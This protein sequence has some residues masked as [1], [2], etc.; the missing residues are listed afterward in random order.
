M[1]KHNDGKKLMRKEKRNAFRLKATQFLK[2]NHRAVAAV[3]IAVFMAGY[4]S[5]VASI[6]AYAVYSGE[7]V[8]IGEPARNI[9]TYDKPSTKISKKHNFLNGIYKL[10]GDYND[11]QQ[12][13]L[14]IGSGDLGAAIY[15][16]TAVERIVFNEKTLW[17]GGPKDGQTDYNGDNFTGVGADGYTENERYY[18]VQDYLLN[19]DTK[20]ATK[21]F[22]NMEGNTENKGAYL[23]FADILIDFGHK[24]VKN[25]TRSLDVDN[26]LASVNYT[27]KDQNF[28]REY[29]ASNP[30]KVVAMRFNTDGELSFTLRFPARQAGATVTADGNE[31]T[32][33][34]ALSG[35]GLKYY[36]CLTVKSHGGTV[37]ANGDALTISGGQTADVFVSAITD[38]KDEYP[39]YRTGESAEV[40]AM[41]V[42]NAVAAAASKGYDGVKK[43]HIADYKNLF[44][45]VSLN[46]GG[47]RPDFTTDKLL[48]KYSTIFLKNSHRRYLEQLLYN[49][50]RYLL[51]A[52]SR[53]DSKLPANLQGV[54]N[55][56][57]N[58]PW[59][60]DYHLNINLQMNYWAAYN[61][62]LAECAEPLVDFVDA[63]R[64]PGRITAKTYT[65][66]AEE[67]AANLAD[68]EYGFIAHTES[69]PYGHTTPGS[70]K[71]V[72]AMWSPAAVAWL[73]Q[74]LYE[75]YEYGQD[76][77]YLARIYPIMKEAARY[78]ERTMV[79]Y[80]GRLVTAPCY[81]PEHGKL[82]AGNTYEQSL[83]WQLLTDVTAAAK[84]LNVDAD[85]QAVWTDMITKLNP[86][87]IGSGG[88][89]KEWYD[90][91]YILSR[92]NAFHR[93]TSHLLGVFPGDLINKDTNPEYVAA[94]K[95]S[96]DWRGNLST[97]WAMGQRI[98]T[99]A[100]L[101][102]GDIAHKLIKTLFK[103][104][105]YPNLFDAHPP[106]QID[107]NFGYTSGVT[108][109]LMQ[110][111]L[112]YIDLLPAL[113]SA[114][115]QGK[116][117]GIVARGNFT[118]A[119][120]WKDGAVTE[121]S[122]RSGSGNECVIRVDNPSDYIVQRSNGTTVSSKISDGKLVFDT[123]VGETYKVIKK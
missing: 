66:T 100:R 111:N 38:Y 105:I 28:S 15:G 61:T 30:D 114:W 17:S 92:G 27:Y 116:I 33:S 64:E 86:I 107:G 83:I 88:Q 97:G 119:Y 49:Y 26:A 11:F 75:G 109:M 3:S 63:L 59:Q 50:G 29:L 12:A 80:N 99:Y 55:E 10:D 115:A 2:K 23:P 71:Y 57:D 47:V 53:A 5:G 118:L 84:T 43:T 98:N 95:V 1:K 62:N 8:T 13:S 44:D 103:N 104:G 68:E 65:A 14:P 72:T 123:A 19:G 56:S 60:S 106:F 22:N 16:E 82:T 91:T 85:K 73:M 35:N 52:S 94:A 24:R 39:T 37:T 70:G 46:L 21:L 67:L 25:Y 40:I 36:A 34:G 78:F 108:E 81:S 20:A 90:E 32:I 93:H 45:R 58:P 121:L 54:W 42:D 74:N 117:S 41:H 120:E 18:A 102:E 110:S 69:S 6:I 122:V 89:I 87:E 113:P 76:K 7:E 9:L 112:G 51:I 48:N 96:L 77:E 79:T 101:G 31:I 4:L